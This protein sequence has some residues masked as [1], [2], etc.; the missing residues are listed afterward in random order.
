MI[1]I[2]KIKDNDN[3]CICGNSKNMSE[4][5]FK[6][7]GGSGHIVILCDMCQKELIEKI[8]RNL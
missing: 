3:A 7:V 8:K 2:K 6:Y 4:V 5:K 1:E